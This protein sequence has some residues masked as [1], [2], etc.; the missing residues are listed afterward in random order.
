[1]TTEVFADSTN[2]QKQNRKNNQLKSIMT[3]NKHVT[4][5][6]KWDE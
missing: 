5:E 4:I 1:M 3:E 6:M 2:T